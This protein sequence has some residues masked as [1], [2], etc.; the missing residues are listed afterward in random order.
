MAVANWKLAGKV[1]YPCAR[2]IVTTLIADG[3]LLCKIATDY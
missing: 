2:L 1:S 3:G